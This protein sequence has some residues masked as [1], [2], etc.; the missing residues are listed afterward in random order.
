MIENQNPAL[1]IANTDTLFPKRAQRLRQWE[2][3]C[4]AGG[5]AA[6]IVR[7]G[8]RPTPDDKHI[9]LGLI[10]ILAMAAVTVSLAVR[11]RWSL[12]RSTFVRQNLAAG[13]FSAFWLAG[14]LAIVIFGP[15]LP[16]WQGISTNRGFAIIACSELFI[17]LR[18]V[19]G[20]VALT[21]K[22]AAG[23][24]N[25]ALVLVVSF[26]I[27]IA[28]GTALLM[29]PR[30][31]AETA[32]VDESLMDRARIALFTSTS[33]SC[34]TGL[35]VV[36]TGGDTP[37]W[38]RTGQTIILCLFQIGGLGIMTWGALFAVIAGRQMQLRESITLGDILESEGPGGVRRLLLTILCFTIGAELIGAL[39]L[40]GLWSDLPFGDRVFY[41]MFHSTSAFCNA[42]FALTNDSFVGMS[43]RWQ[44][45]GALSG[46][47]IT[48]GLGFAVLYNIALFIRSQRSVIRTR[49]LFNFPKDHVRV[50]ITS[51]LVVG[52]TVAL[53]LFG[54]VGY[55]VLEALPGAEGTDYSVDHEESSGQRI[56]DAWF[57]SVTFRTAGFNTVDHGTQKPATKLF[58]IPLMIVGASPGS[59]GGGVKTISFALA[60]LALASVLRGRKRVE[61]MGRNIPDEQ[62]RRALGILTLGM[63][64]V[65]AT[66]ILLVLFERQP[67]MLVDHLY[68]AASAFAT[69]GVSTGVTPRLSPPSQFVIIVT[70]FI[71]RVGPLTL[72]MGLGGRHADASYDYPDERVTLG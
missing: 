12:A 52:T 63:L 18:G 28:A 65:M 4:Q 50:S 59:T 51:K 16:E 13:L 53:L 20:V 44:V 36:D 25:P 23:G 31:R 46:L 14:L 9:E 35:V 43:T 38:S 48:G 29:L 49:P 3:F 57:Q 40:S 55:Y 5:V 10:V 61:F 72:L 68:E 64:I 11:H 39:L 6:A 66:T 19:A 62:V 15:I 67:E 70:M 2:I 71:G 21:R 47:I 41:S 32:P 37:Y 45:W 30:A 60:V 58:A 33:A 54:M 26:V 42:G 8:L 17:M 34:V 1:T 69:V 7:H 22:A 24:V 27:L 56:A